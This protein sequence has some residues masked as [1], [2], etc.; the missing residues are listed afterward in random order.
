M[1][2]R[3]T[4][5]N[6]IFSELKAKYPDATWTAYKLGENNVN[7]KF[8]IEEKKYFNN[9]YKNIVEYENDNK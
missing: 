4:G 2:N 5:E 3:V 1:I 9:N 7:H 6:I 8:R